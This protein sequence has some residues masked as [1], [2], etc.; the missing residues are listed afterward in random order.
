MD[1]NSKNFQ[2]MTTEF[3]EFARRVDKGDRLYMRALSADKPTAKPAS[4]ADDFAALA[5]D[6]VLPPQLSFVS[7]NLFSSVLRISGPVNMWLHYDVGKTVCRVPLKQ[8]P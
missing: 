8:E 1:F 3:S 7:D 5:D 4:L 6:F 2:Y